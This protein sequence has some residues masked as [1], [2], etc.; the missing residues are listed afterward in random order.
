MPLYVIWD[1]E[2]ESKGRQIVLG[3]PDQY[4]LA[5]HPPDKTDNYIKRCI[6]VSGDTIQIKKSRVYINSV[7][8]P[9]PPQS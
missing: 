9:L 8:Q 4:P 7:L 3:N 6:G 5:I 2:N 1:K